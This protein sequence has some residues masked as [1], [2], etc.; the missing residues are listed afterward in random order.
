[1]TFSSGTPSD[2]RVAKSCAR[3]VFLA[4]VVLYLDSACC[5]LP[6]R[7]FEDPAFKIITG[8]AHCS[9]VSLVLCFEVRH[10]VRYLRL[11][12]F[13]EINPRAR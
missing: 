7:P 9:V 1:M 4:V 11:D 2:P 5:A 12:E 13:E 10:I 6:L 8:S 3:P